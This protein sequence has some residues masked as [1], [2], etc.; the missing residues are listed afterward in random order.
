MLARVAGYMNVDPGRFKLFLY[1]EAGQ[2][3]FLRADDGTSP[4]SAG[5]YVQQDVTIDESTQRAAIGIEASMLNDPVALV[6]TL[7]HEVAHEILIGQKLISTSE[8]DHEPLTDLVTV[9]FGMGIFG[10]NSTIRDAGWSRGLSAGWHARRLGYLDQR[11]FGYA[12]ARFAETRG[13]TR[14][15]WIKH[16]RPDVRVPL[17]QSLRF[18][19]N[20]R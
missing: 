19:R 9:F 6:A 16:V 20:A 13:E 14:P 15:S 10:A 3:A 11:A 7:A 18:L 5:L 2:R 12:L 1:S 17:E 8:P 4:G